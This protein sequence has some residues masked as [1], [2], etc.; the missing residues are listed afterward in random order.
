MHAS[1]ESVYYPDYIT[2]KVAKQSA[3]I[4]DNFGYDTKIIP[5]TEEASMKL[6][7][8]ETYL[9]RVIEGCN[10][11][12]VIIL[13][14][15]FI[16]A[17]SGKLKTTFLYLLLGSVLIYLVNLLRIVLLSIALYHYPEYREILHTIVFPAI[18]YG[19][20]FLLWIVWVNRFSKLNTS[21]A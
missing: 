5:H 13:F 11:F 10:G 15:A 14:I 9:A 7:L 12:S 8:N 2:N 21:N 18:I 6:F 17:F 4:L 16:V 3:A 19:L 1:D 20:V